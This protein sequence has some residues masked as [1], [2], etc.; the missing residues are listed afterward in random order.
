MNKI[1]FA[2]RVGN[3]N[4]IYSYIIFKEINSDEPF[5]IP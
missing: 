1:N 5:Q 2:L 3:M 4:H